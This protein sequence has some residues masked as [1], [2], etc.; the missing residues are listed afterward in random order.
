MLTLQWPRTLRVLAHLGLVG[1]ALAA[2]TA[3]AQIVRPFNSRFSVNTNG[4]IAL[5]GNMNVHCPATD[6][7]AASG[8]ANCDS[9]RAGGNFN[10]N[11][12]NGAYVNIDPGAGRFSSSRAYLN[13]PNGSTVLWAGLYWGASSDGSTGN[14]TIMQLRTPAG[15]GYNTIAASQFDTFDAGGGAGGIGMTYSAF[16]DVTALVTAGGAGD[17]YGANIVSTTGTSNKYGGWAL[18][19]VFQNNTLPLR[20]L[21]VFDGYIHVNPAN[22]VTVPVS[23]FLT[24]LSGPIVSRLGVLAFDGDRNLTGDT[25]SLN[26]VNIPAVETAAANNFFRSSNNDLGTINTNRYPAY[27]NML[28]MDLIRVNAPA[29]SITNGMT[30]ATIQV[31][32]SNETVLVPVVSFITDIYVPIITPNVVKTLTD[33]NGGDLLPGDTIRWNIVLS[34]TGFD[35]GTNVILTDN[36]PAYTTYVPG[37]MRINTGANSSPPGKT[38]MPMDDQAEYLTTGGPPRVVFRLGTGANTTMGGN[39]PYQASTSISFDTTLDVGV[40]AG[41]LIT[42]SAQ[43]QYSGQTLG[44]QFAASSAAAAS[45]IRAAPTLGKSFSPNPINLG[46][47]SVLTIVVTNPSNNTGT[48]TGVSFTDTYPTGIANAAVPNP[49][50]SCTVGSSGAIAVGTGQAGGSTIG[51]STGN[52]ALGGSCTITV[53]VVGTANGNHTNA[54]TTIN[55]NGT[56]NTINTNAILSVGK[57]GITKA[58]GSAQAV[59]NVATTMTIT[60]TNPLAVALTG[61]NFTDSFP[62]GLQIAPTPG[63]TN[64]CTGTVSPGGTAGDTALNLTGGTIPAFG[65]C[66]ITVNV[67]GTGPGTKTNTASGVSSTQTGAAGQPATAAIDIIGNPVANKSFF[68]PS[69]AQNGLSTLTITVTNPN[70]A[71][72]MT[73]VAFTDT[74]P[75]GSPAGT[76]LNANPANTTIN[77]T[78][79][80]SA[81]LVGGA[82]SG[83]T[84]GI[85]AGSLAPNGSCTVSVS[86]TSATAPAPTNTFNNSTGSISSTNAGTGA[87]ATASLV[88]TS[89]LPPT[90]AKSFS[91][92]NVQEGGN[93]TLTITLTNP[94]GSATITGISFNDAYPAN[95]VNTSTPMV[96][97]TGV[98]STLTLTGAN[99]GTSV[100]AS[101]GV[102]GPSGVCTITVSVTSNTAAS[103]FNSTG[104]VTTANAGVQLTPATATL[105]VLTP[106]ELVKAFAVAAI[107]TGATTTMTLRVNNPNTVQIT[108][109][110]YADTLP[111]GLTAVNGTTANLCGAG[112]SLVIA[113]ASPS[114]TVTLTGGIVAAASNCTISVTVTGATAGIKN[115]TTG[116][117]SASGPT[118]LTGLPSNTASLLVGLPS[119]AKSFSAASVALNGTATMSF[120]IT[121]TSTAV[122][123][124]AFTDPLP[125]GLTA[126]NG[127]TSTCGGGSLVISGGNMLTFSGGA[128]AASAS[129]TINVTVTGAQVGLWANT[130]SALSS[131]LGTGNPSNTA[132]IVVN[133]PPT[134][135][136]SFSTSA[137]ALSGTATLSLVIA[138]PN[139]TVNFT[140]VA[141]TDPL[142]AGL[143]AVNGTTSVCGGSLAITGTNLLTFTGGTL[144]AG[145]TC[146]ISVTVT[147]STSGVKNNTTTAISSTQGGTGSVSNTATITVAPTAPTISK[148]FT[149]STIAVGDTSSMTFTL[150]NANTVAT[151]TGVAFTDTLP[152][153]LTA[154]N[155][156]VPVCGGSLAVSGGNS[157]TFT[158]GSLAPSSN[159]TIT[160]SVIGA[161]AGT[162]N[163][164][165]GVISSTQTGAG[166]TSNT[167]TLT[168]LSQPDLIIGKT[169]TGNFTQGQVGATYTIIVANIGSLAKPMGDT[170]TVVDTLPAGLTATAISGT[171]WSCTLGTLTCTRTDVL[172]ANASYP[173]ITV[174]VNVNVQSTL[175]NNTV[176]VSTSGTDSDPGNN[177]AI[178]PTAVLTPDLTLTKTHVGNFTVGV[179]GVFTITPSNALGNAATIGTITVTDT[180]PAG[181][182]YISG[183]GTGW[184]CGAV[185]QAVTCTSSTVIPAGMVGNPITLTVAVGATAAPGVTNIARISGGAEPAS[186]NGSNDAID[187]VNVSTVPVNTFLTDG[188]QTGAPGSS[189]L[190][191]HNFNANLTGTVGFSTSDVATPAITGWTNQIYRDTNCDGFLNGVEGATVLTGTIAVTP[192]TQVCIIVKSN[193]P[194]SAPVGAQD[195]ITVTASFTPSMGPVVTYSRVDITTV[196]YAGGSGLALSKQVRNVTQ[197]GTLGTS[198][199]AR[200]ADTLEYVITYTN[201][202]ST[203]LN[204]IVINDVTPAYTRYVAANCNMPFPANI[205]ACSVPIQPAVNGTGPIRWSLTGT[206][207]PGQTGTIFFRVTVN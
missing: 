156:T 53:N 3:E 177:T 107:N 91:P 151:L 180:L 121:N 113:G 21:S 22:T 61:V 35:T 49:Q 46:N 103:Y 41:T 60:V 85:S 125:T 197:S 152:A 170:V 204:S 109:V 12:F 95:V 5:A 127:T 176:T 33:L 145:A 34:N 118:S 81:T 165:T 181:L 14:R 67:I 54:I 43:I 162:K 32:S 129:C 193:I 72:T 18:F 92:A 48:V 9:A 64:T 98:G 57:P 150:T 206:L 200:P 175:V 141:F 110:S 139:N 13:I 93:S 104:S 167:A 149:P 96:S 87:A 144:A 128:L 76:M 173:N 135:S 71:L 117:V 123:G 68:P 1:F 182:T 58:F 138:N 8:N 194:A 65:T 146:T 198:N 183:T 84:L 159:C 16:R 26:G 4:D 122:T 140:G 185:M 205:T 120:V 114:Q 2:L 195:V 179:N 40:P 134:I 42:N 100:G 199:S 142:P 105:N 143:T 37:S 90:L 202:S 111:A 203:P 55:F 78:A 52:I 161:T 23:G 36:I 169:H 196:G 184:S 86:V 207:A 188:A 99:G 19:V 148:A 201:S 20:N 82:N 75:A 106:P 29:G 174:T 187:M 132:V 47:T 15:T 137:I 112:S 168:V 101:T 172:A 6:P 70:S 89:V 59:Q 126:P 25:M 63:L 77:C 88:V 158:A 56:S 115:N 28:G 178:D 45:P 50:L 186:L 108:G 153:G 51:F 27:T 31:A 66:T 155:G 97:C 124:L 83:N 24:P 102:L 160:V 164:T 166:A 39:I 119:I 189:V 191:T 163:N 154:V 10:D 116:P 133:A 73:G 17:Y 30:S 157:L 79:G 62:S 130:T 7:A 171:G 44:A 74:Y 192:G 190:Y 94:S 11:D 136:K 80:S 147:G 38:D 69:I 131:S